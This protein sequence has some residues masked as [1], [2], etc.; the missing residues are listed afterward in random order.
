MAGAPAAARGGQAGAALVLAVLAVAGCR[1]GSDAGEGSGGPPGFVLPDR[2]D[3]LHE[4]LAFSDPAAFRAG[5][6]GGVPTIELVGS[7]RYQPPVRS[8]L[9]IALWKEHA[10]GDFVLDVDVQ[11]TG[12][13]YGHRDLCFVF[14]HEAPDRFYYVHIAT[15]AD[16]HAH[17]VFLVNG[18]PRTAIAT[19][20]T[21]GVAWGDVGDWH[22][23]RIERRGA[24]IRV[25]FDD[26][27][28]PIMEAEDATLGAGRIGFGSFDDT[29]VFRDVSVVGRPS[30]P[31]PG[32]LFAE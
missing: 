19:R 29:G 1:S 18:A 17:N 4:A 16:P 32:P 9:A 21:A 3:A 25:W 12:R 2:P 20:T 10:F 27:Q 13:E 24:T 26:L 6:D 31:A 23:V 8:P 22:H 28:S 5:V 14:G 30:E 15:K 11:Q 7:A